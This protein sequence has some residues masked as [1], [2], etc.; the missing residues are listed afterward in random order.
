M[1]VL[2]CIVCMVAQLGFLFDWFRLRFGRMRLIENCEMKKEAK[3]V[4]FL[5][6]G[7]VGS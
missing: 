5:I 6:L 2:Y 1:I 4:A 3:Q 7:V